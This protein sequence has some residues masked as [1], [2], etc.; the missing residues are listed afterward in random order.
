MVNRTIALVRYDYFQTLNGSVQFFRSIS[1]P[2]ISTLSLRRQ[3]KNSQ[4]LSETTILSQ[5]PTSSRLLPHSPP[6]LLTVPQPLIPSAGSYKWL[7]I[8]SSTM[9]L[10]CLSKGRGFHFPPCHMLNFCGVRILFDCPLDLSSLMAFSPHTYFF[11]C[12]VI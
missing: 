6:P 5:Q 9:K 1:S 12:L 7:S 2:P 3:K 11:G 4:T 8:S 10:T